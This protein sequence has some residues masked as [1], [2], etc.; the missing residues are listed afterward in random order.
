MT[1]NYN[2]GDPALVEKLIRFESRPK[3]KEQ[4]SNGATKPPPLAPIATALTRLDDWLARD[5]PEPDLLLGDVLS[6]TTRALLWAP[7]GIG[8]TMLII[9]AAMHMAG[10]RVFLGWRAQRP[11]R[12]LYI[13]GEMS[14]KL[15]LERLRGE[16][17]RSGIRPEGFHALSHE[18]IENWAP[19]NTPEGQRQ[20]EHHIALL[21]PDFI[22]FDSIMCLI[23]GDMKEE[24]GWR[25]TVPWMLSL[26]RRKI[27]QMWVHHTGHDTSHGYGTKTREWL[28]DTVI[29]LSE[30]KREDTDVSFTLSFP[31]ARMRTP[32]TRAQFADKRVALVNDRW[33]HGPAGSAPG[34]ISP[35]AR[36]FYEA[37]CDA[38][39]DDDTKMHGRPAATQVAWKATCV[40]MGLLDKDKPDSARSIFSRHRLEL[41]AANHVACSDTMAW[42]PN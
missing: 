28:L 41:I 27:G 37:L 29:G 19:L 36:K 2:P 24:E 42:V 33:E 26:T 31:K 16:V 5:I 38:I 21:N 30:V 10:E 3:R 22:F 4:S 7:T 6:T 13:D 11:C 8:K 15:L 17:E 14:N 20:I 18:D 12:V 25:Q 23:Q 40:K 35:L 32:Q 9:A 39:S 34:H 1:D